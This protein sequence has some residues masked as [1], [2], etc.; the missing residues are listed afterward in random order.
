MKNSNDPI[1]NPTGDSIWWIKLLYGDVNSTKIFAFGGNRTHVLALYLR[2]YV[3]IDEMFIYQGN[4]TDRAVTGQPRND[5]S[6]PCRSKR[7]F[8]PPNR[9]DRLWGQPSLRLNQGCFTLGYSD[10]GDNFTSI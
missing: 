2:P 5:G 4:S 3:A 10:G 1:R 6:I 9:A 7:F 8:S